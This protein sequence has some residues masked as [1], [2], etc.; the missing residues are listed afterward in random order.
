M[1]KLGL[2]LGGGGARAAAH[3]GAL[4]ELAKMGVKPDLITGTSAGGVLGGMLAAGMLPEEM[5]A[6]LKELSMSQIYGLPSDGRS[7]SSNHKMAALLEQYIGRPTFADLEIPLAVVAVNLQTNQEV[8]LGEGDVIDALLATAAFPVLFPPVMIDGQPLID[9]GLVNNVPFDVA[10]ARGAAG[11]IAISLDNSS[12][13][14][15][16]EEDAH[17]VGIW[18]R[19]M[20]QGKRQPLWQIV[21]AVSDIITRRSV[22]ARQAISPPDIMLRPFIGDT[23]LFDFGSI[24]EGMAAGK[25]AVQEAADDIQ[26]LLTRLQG[27]PE[28]S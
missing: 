10:R 15:E 13:Y 5:G 19:V 1:L 25:Q 14:G 20:L 27:R 17:A 18:E 21:T 22:L 2:A 28:E 16:F 11:V 7:L 23:G 6:I 12:P 26:A 4:I 8:I 9:G 24:E 3:V